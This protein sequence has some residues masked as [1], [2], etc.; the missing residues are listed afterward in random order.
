[1]SGRRRPFSLGPL[2]HRAFRRVWI[3]RT[4]SGFGDALVPVATAFAVLKLGTASDLGYVFAAYIG[5]RMLFLVVGGVYADRLPRQLVMV[6]SDV[7]RCITHGLIAVAFAT[8]HAAIWQLTAA[9]AIFGLGSAFFGPASTAL[10]P[11]IV[12][13]TLLQQANSLLNLGASASE[14]AGPAL[15]GVLIA[16]SGYT[17]IYA[18]D[19]ATFAVSAVF[20]LVLG[21]PGW[22][23]KPRNSKFLGDVRDGARQV[24]VHQWLKWGFL[25][26]ALSNFAMAPYWVLGPVLVKHQFAGA[27]D[28]GFMMTAGAVGGVI[29]AIVGLRLKPARP[30]IVS[31]PV[32]V[33]LPLEMTLLAIH[34]PLPLLIVGAALVIVGIVISNTLWQATVQAR[35]P[36][37]ILGRVD[38][39]DWMVSL[40]C[41]P[42][43]YVVSGPAAQLIG[44]ENALLAAAAL[45]AAANLGVVAFP[46]IRAV[47]G[48]VPAGD[49][50][51][52]PAAVVEV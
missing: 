18:I 15:A 29:A 6:A 16:M 1:M 34:A 28:W 9:S 21:D 36:L 40:V 2:H 24:L 20:L 33:C 7:V 46:S 5:S 23:P 47:R 44:E 43:G 39:F 3:A 25:C 19:A 31:F 52:Q 38:S 30:L 32:M 45:A 11:S 50:P 37:G 35:M 49:L 27:R 48:V 22:S 8:G 4:T 17:A 51:V 13:T 10:V 12:P 14:I 42:L 41:T 26:F